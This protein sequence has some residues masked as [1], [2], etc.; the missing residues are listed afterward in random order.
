MSSIKNVFYR[1]IIVCTSITVHSLI[2]PRR[3][4]THNF[5]GENIVIRFCFLGVEFGNQR[6]LLLILNE[7]IY[8]ESRFWKIGV[9]WLINSAIYLFLR[10]FSTTGKGDL[11]RTKKEDGQSP[12]PCGMPKLT[13]RKVREPKRRKSITP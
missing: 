1:Y 4:F 12:S 13:G 5:N 11:S 3:G 7:T 6:E 9:I 2:T 10:G 8:T